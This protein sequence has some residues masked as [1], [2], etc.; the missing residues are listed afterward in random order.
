MLL[1]S[2]FT[3]VMKNCK[4]CQERVKSFR[5]MDLF[6]QTI[7]LILSKSA[8]YSKKCIITF[9]YYLDQAVSLTFERNTIR[10]S[11]MQII[12]SFFSSFVCVVFYGKVTK[13]WHKLFHRMWIFFTQLNFFQRPTTWSTLGVGSRTSG[14]QLKIYSGL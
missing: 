5:E 2:T 13:I 6:S 8:F 9:T 1:L 14:V 12:D 11:A 7:C 3:V 10:I 4:S